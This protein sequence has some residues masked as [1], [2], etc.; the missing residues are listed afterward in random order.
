M[1]KLYLTLDFL[2]KKHE[3]SLLVDIINLNRLYLKPLAIIMKR[4]LI[5]TIAT[6]FFSCKME[7]KKLA[8]IGDW[9]STSDTNINMDIHFFND[10]I[11]VDNSAM[12]GTY[13]LIWEVKDS[14]IENYVL[15]NN[16]Y[17]EQSKIII[18]YKFSSNKDTLYIKNENDSLF[19]I[20]FR[21]IKNNFEYL[22][23]RIGLK[24]RLPKTSE[25]LTTIGNKEFTFKIYIGKNN[26]S[27]IVKTDNSHSLNQLKYN[28][29][30]SYLSKKKGDRDSLTLALFTD[31]SVLENEI[32]S[33]KTILKKLPI[34]SFFRIYH[35]NQY[36]GNNLKTEI[37]WLG[38]YEN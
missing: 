3:F 34:K 11:V 13:S 15:R 33:I 6:I 9:S 2:I 29:Y 30:S 8:F 10:S 1:F 4:I 21:K 38:K 5:F 17:I 24:L 22:E 16:G 36:T 32:D 14:Q 37:K 27:L 25:K 26:D 23:N 12:L 35:D 19:E 18:N 31:K 28:V 20:S 7:N